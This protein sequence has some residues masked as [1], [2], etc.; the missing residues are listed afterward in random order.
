V[1]PE[2]RRVVTAQTNFTE[3]AHQ[4][5]SGTTVERQALCASTN[6]GVGASCSVESC[7]SLVVVVGGITSTVVGVGTSFQPELG[8]HAPTEVF[9]TAE[10]DAARSCA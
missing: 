8:F 9:N 5:D 2:L 3:A 7:H 10:T 4:A 1:V 6:R